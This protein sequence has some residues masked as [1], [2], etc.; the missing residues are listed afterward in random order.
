MRAGNTALL[1]GAVEDGVLDELGLSLVPLDPPSRRAEAEAGAPMASGA[2]SLSIRTDRGFQT[3]AARGPVETLYRSEGRPVALLAPLGDGRVVLVSDAFPAGNEGLPEAGNAVFVLNALE[4]A[5]GGGEVIFNETGTCLEMGGTGVL[6]YLRQAGAQALFL[7]LV[8]LSLLALWCLSSR[9]GP[10]A[11]RR[12]GPP[13][14]SADYVTGM[15]ILYERAAM[16]RNAVN[17]LSDTLREAARP[18]HFPAW[19]AKIEARRA[20]LLAKARALSLRRS[21][22]E[23]DLVKFGRGVHDFLRETLWKPRRTVRSER[24][25]GK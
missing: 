24:P 10:P 15:A 1:L 25:S 6:S 9:I 11:T 4:A 2:G 12:A 16:G 22:G 23:S 17:L 20:A 21:V 13:R 19:P 14:G 18:A 3:E 7:E 5:R 8:L